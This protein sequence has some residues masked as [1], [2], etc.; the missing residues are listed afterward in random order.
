METEGKKRK[1]KETG[2]G[3]IEYLI[4]ERIDTQLKKIGISK[5]ELAVKAGIAK[6]TF[7]NWAARK[8][9][10]PADIAITIA[11]ALGCSVRW[12]ITGVSDKQEEYTFEEKEMIRKFRE[13]DEQGRR[14][15][16]ALLNTK[17]SDKS[18]RTEVIAAVEKKR[19]AG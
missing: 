12:L 4:V 14:Y 8:T 5:P 6:N 13:I 9:I 3:N 15:L 19:T 10:P 17:P 1:R 11:D 16:E 18:K 7:A 2:S